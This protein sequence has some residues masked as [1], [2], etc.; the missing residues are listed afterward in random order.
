MTDNVRALFS[1]HEQVES[2]I[3]ALRSDGI[4]AGHI[5]VTGPDG[6][7]SSVAD[8]SERHGFGAHLLGRLL[9]HDRSPEHV[10]PTAA[11]VPAGWLV[12]VSVDREAEDQS[13]RNL[14]IRAGA[15]QISSAT[16]G[17]M[18]PLERSGRA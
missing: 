11:G 10:Q 16:D 15:T 2:V 17:T 4:E 12:S 13:A 8:A 5:T 14:F 7:I 1:S 18:V 3:G 9:R 6:T